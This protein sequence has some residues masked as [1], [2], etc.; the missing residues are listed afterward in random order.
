MGGIMQVG[1]KM[2]ER[3]PGLNKL[4]KVR[5]ISNYSND[6]QGGLSGRDLAAATMAMYECNSMDYLETRIGQT[7]YL[8]QELVKR[9][10]PIVWPPGGH[11]IF[12]KSNELIP[13]EMKPWS[14]FASMGFIIEL[15]RLYG[16]RAI[17][18]GYLSAGIDLQVEKNGG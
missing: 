4:L 15:C 8:G 13:P 17:E 3:F 7:Q 5:Q 12:I 14:D 10:I 16:I 11:G 18:M 6:S 9:G 2:I 1:E